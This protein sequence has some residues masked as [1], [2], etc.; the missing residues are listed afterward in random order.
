M[1]CDPT[2]MAH[3]RPKEHDGGMD[4]GDIGRRVHDS[5]ITATALRALWDAAR[6]DREAARAIRLG[7]LREAAALLERARAEFGSDM[8]ADALANLRSR[9]SEVAGRLADLE[10]ELRAASA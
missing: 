8:A 10:E 4:T 7:A 3:G 1:K 9:L 6:A 2:Q 5:E